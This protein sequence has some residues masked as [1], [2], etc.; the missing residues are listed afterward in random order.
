MAIDS[1][2]FKEASKERIQESLGE[3]F[4]ELLGEALLANGAELTVKLVAA[5]KYGGDVLQAAIMLQA[6]A[7]AASFAEALADRISE[8]LELLAEEVNGQL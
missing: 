7:M 6:S 3:D 5:A 8:E 4:A 1:G 2:A